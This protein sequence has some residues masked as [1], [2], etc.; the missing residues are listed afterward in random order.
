[1]DAGQN[2][3]AGESGL[4]VDLFTCNEYCISIVNS[5]LKQVSLHAIRSSDGAAEAQSFTAAG[6]PTN[7][8]SV[9][10]I[11]GGHIRLQS[12]A[13]TTPSPS[14][15]PL[16]GPRRNH[17]N[18]RRPEQSV[19]ASAS[20]TQEMARNSARLQKRPRISYADSEDGDLGHDVDDYESDFGKVC[21][22]LISPHRCWSG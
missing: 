19:A 7:W 16:S 8:V 10:S 1:M 21:S 4:R 11:P 20:L 5:F 2:P 12:S 15:T 6:D 17:N 13:R 9:L 22:N 18:T 3:D 14:P